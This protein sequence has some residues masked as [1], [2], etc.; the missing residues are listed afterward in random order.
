MKLESHLSSNHIKA[1][2]FDLDG[3]LRLNIPSGGDVFADY[4]AKLGLPVNDEDRLRASRWENY[5]WASSRE[6]IKDKQKFLTEPDF[7][8]HYARRQLAALGASREQVKIM[9]SKVSQFMEENFHPQSDLPQGAL[10]ALSELHKAGYTMAVVSNRE[11][12][13]QQEI[14]GLGLTEFF[15]FSLAAGEFNSYKPNPEIFI[16]ACERADVKPADAVY[17]GDN[18]FADVVGALR[19]GLQ[20]VLFDPKRIFPEAESECPVIKSFGQLFSI[21]KTL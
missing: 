20:P 13:Y 6:V 7:W 2:F 3:T 21:I 15:S 5:Y 11:K 4:A 9:A 8:N 16:H 19:A 14:D 1:V 12:P 17:V 10:N 18:Y